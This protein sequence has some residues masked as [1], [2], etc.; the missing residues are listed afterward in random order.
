ML[1]FLLGEAL[2]KGKSKTQQAIGNKLLDNA[3]VW[4]RAEVNLTE[5]RRLVATG[6]RKMHFSKKISE[7][8]KTVWKMCWRAVDR[9][10]L[11]TDPQ[12]LKAVLTLED[13]EKIR[14]LTRIPGPEGGK[15]GEVRRK[16]EHYL[17][18]MMKRKKVGG[19]KVMTKMSEKKPPVVSKK[20]VRG[21]VDF[22]STNML[23]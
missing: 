3:C 19:K 13:R 12:R 9:V 20:Q 6:L 5:G 14:Q 23:I 2:S 11:N 8:V 17:L 1:Q 22:L 21:G 18:Q 10:I 15:E 4:R 7:R 16:C